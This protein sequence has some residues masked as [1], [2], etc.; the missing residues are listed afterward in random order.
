MGCP[1]C[2][3]LGKAF[4][5]FMRCTGQVRDSEGGRVAGEKGGG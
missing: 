1:D 3:S 5:A 4:F 2:T